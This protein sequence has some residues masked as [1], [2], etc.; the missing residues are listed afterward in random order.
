MVQAY[1]HS[2]CAHDSREATAIVEF[3]TGFIAEV[4]LSSIKMVQPHAEVMEAKKK[5]LEQVKME[6]ESRKQRTT[7]PV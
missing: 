6:Q 3:D 5:Y 2:F 1:V 4:N 7:Q